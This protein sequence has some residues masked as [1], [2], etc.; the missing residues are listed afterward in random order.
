ML[1]KSCIRN[2][3]RQ[4]ISPSFSPLFQTILV[5]Y[6]SYWIEYMALHPVALLKISSVDFDIS[7]PKFTKK[8][9]D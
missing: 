7:Y 6:P 2:L 9:S 3:V 5:V 1:L 4:Q 8:C